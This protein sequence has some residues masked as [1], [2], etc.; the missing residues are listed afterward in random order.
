[1]KQF[2][3]LLALL[4]ML[5]VPCLAQNKSWTPIFN[6][7]NLDGWDSYLGV[8]IDSAGK[9][10]GNTPVGF[11]NDPKQV[12]SV[13]K[14]DGVKVIRISGDGVG[15]LISKGEFENY[16]LQLQF[17]WGGWLHPSRKAKDSGVLYHSVGENGADSGAWMRSQ[18]FQIQFGDCGDYIGCAGA[19]ADVPATNKVYDPKAPLVTISAKS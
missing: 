8:P 5:S 13:V 19:L 18:E 14:Q 15:G 9:K 2:T 12:F 7:N 3:V 4:L 10:I 17:K 16:H 1:M 11:N 6:G